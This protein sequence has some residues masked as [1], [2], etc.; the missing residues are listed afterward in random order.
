MIQHPGKD[1]T[2]D[3]ADG[4]AARNSV[5]GTM[6]RWGTGDGQGTENITE[7][8]VTAGIATP[9]TAHHEEGTLTET[10]DSG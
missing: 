10:M 9:Q 8:P 4:S 5:R 7:D 2:S 3:T 6:T 1:R